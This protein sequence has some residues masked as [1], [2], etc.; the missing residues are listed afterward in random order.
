MNRRWLHS[1]TD[2]VIRKEIKKKCL[3]KMFWTHHTFDCFCFFT[4][5]QQQRRAQ[6]LGLIRRARTHTEKKKKKK[7]SRSSA[8]CSLFYMVA[9]FLAVFR[10]LGSFCSLLRADAHTHTWGSVFGMFILR[11]RKASATVNEINTLHAY[12]PL[13]IIINGELNARLCMQVQHETATQMD[14][15][16]VQFYILCM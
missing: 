1:P 4:V 12:A 5:L 14:T 13:Y 3:G 10:Q 2:R 8:H 11:R 7:K 16:H 9:L 15:K 6:T